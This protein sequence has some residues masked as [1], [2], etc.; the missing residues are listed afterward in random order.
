MITLLMSSSPVRS[1]Y[2]PGVSPA[3][4]SFFDTAR[5]SVSSISELL[6]EPDT[7]VTQTK[8]PSGMYKSTPRRLL[9]RAPRSPI[10]PPAGVSSPSHDS[11]IRRVAGMGISLR[12]ERYCPVSDVEDFETA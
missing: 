3:R 11:R 8:V 2:G 12:P 5:A 1:S 4:L 6:P 9:R 10:H 7:P